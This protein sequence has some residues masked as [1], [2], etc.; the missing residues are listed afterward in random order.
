MRHPSGQSVAR[1][2][3]TPANAADS[4]IFMRD[5]RGAPRGPLLEKRMDAVAPVKVRAANR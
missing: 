2:K 1:L 3:I 4:T 5:G